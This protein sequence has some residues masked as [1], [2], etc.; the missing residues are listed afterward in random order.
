MFFDTYFLCSYNYQMRKLLLVDCK[1]YDA[2]R[3]PESFQQ[4]VIENRNSYMACLCYY[5]KARK[6]INHRTVPIILGSYIDFLIRGLDAV[7][8][9]REQWGAVIL[10]GVLKIYASFSTFDALSLH[11]RETKTVKS[12]DW[13]TYVPNETGNGSDGLALNYRDKIVTWTYRY[14]TTNSVESNEWIDLL[15]RSNPFRNA[16]SA[17]MLGDDYIKMFDT[18][19]RY[20]YNMNDLKNRQFLNGATIISKYINH[21]LN[22][23][24][25]KKGA[26]C[27]KM[28]I[29]FEQGTLFQ[30]LS[31]KNFNETEEWCRNYPQN[32]DNTLHEGRSNKT[33]ILLPNITRASNDAVRNSNALAFPSDAVN[34]FCMLN[35]KDLKSA[36]EQNVLADFV[37]MSEETD[38]R[39]LH[40]CLGTMASGEGNILVINGYI[41]HYR[42]PWT[43]TD[44][45]RIKRQC[46]HVTTKYYNP[47]VMFSTRSSIPLKYS[48]EHDVFF[49]PAETIHFK[50]VY[51]EAET[52]STAAKQL[53]V[54]NIRKTAPAKV[55]VSINNIKGSVANVTSDL[56]RL[57]ME[58]SLGITCYMEMTKEKRQRLIDISVLS[59]GHDTTD[60]WTRYRE[61]EREFRLNEDALPITETNKANAMRALSRLYPAEDLFVECKR[62][63]TSPFVLMRNTARSDDIRTYLSTI[64]NSRFYYPKEVWNLRLRAVFGNP[65]GAC[66]EDGV[67]LDSKTVQHIPH[68][69]YNAC[70]TIEFTFKTVKQPR[71]AYFIRID[72]TEGEIENETLIGCIV[73]PYEAYVKNSKH[74][75]IKMSRIGSHY[76]YLIH[77]LPKKTNMYKN[78]KINHIRSG[79]SITIVIKGKTEVSVVDGSKMAN[80]YGQKNVCSM[81]MDLSDCWGITRD[82][83]KVHAQI[84]YSEASIIGRV[85]SGQIYDMLRSD[86]LAIGPNGEIIAPIDLVVHTLHPYTNNKVFDIKVDTLTNINGF[87]SQNLCNTSLALRSDTVYEKVLQVL[88][89]HGFDIRFIDNTQENERITRVPLTPTVYEPTSPDNSDDDD[90]D[91]EKKNE[92]DESPKRAKDET[93]DDEDEPS[94]KRVKEET[95]DDEDDDEPSPKR[96][97]EETDDDDE[98]DSQ[99]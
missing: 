60:F 35:T 84:V 81:T 93:D 75:L 73:S 16:S 98:D 67:V 43:L 74:S 10:K 65:Y 11:V 49:S 54:V 19:L 3:T 42:H 58:N 78:L 96:V 79:N 72:E 33:S 26:G 99:A 47:Y 62:T 90:D 24:R 9:C 50:I 95:D 17:Q 94:P 32:Y 40:Q 5:S 13:Y 63:Q 86:E 38:P 87:D 68:I 15:D 23:R 12:I 69:F 36:G 85:P 70:I 52:L 34:F 71:S 31:K 83:R 21:D 6:R 20:Q 7:I 76:Y 41:T 82:G 18:M 53:S 92:T 97:K 89:L 44:L 30:A 91:D 45:V 55:T 29:A 80:S 27:L 56:H 66:I 88:G 4:R 25:K 39:L 57:L 37:F 8:E 1:C 59:E 22:K 61:L 51:P 28:S 48:D 2:Y 64:F 46:G 77:F 14:R